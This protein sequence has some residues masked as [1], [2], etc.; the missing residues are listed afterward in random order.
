MRTTTTVVA[1]HYRLQ[2]WVTQIQEC[3]NRPSGMSISDWCK[4]QGITKANYYYCL[5]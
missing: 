1:R 2:Q 5:R 4:Q 3:Q